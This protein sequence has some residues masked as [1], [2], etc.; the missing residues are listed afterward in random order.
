[1]ERLIRIKTE[2]ATLNDAKERLK[3][4]IKTA[5]ECIRCSIF[6]IDEEAENQVRDT[7]VEQ[8]IFVD[9]SQFDLSANQIKFD[10]E[11]RPEELDDEGILLVDH[12]NNVNTDLP[13]DLEVE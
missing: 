1:M 6:T 10:I 5:K 12:H 3:Q 9:N 11:E 4:T 7:E 8:N 2:Q 13:E